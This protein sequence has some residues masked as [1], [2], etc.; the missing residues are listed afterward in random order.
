MTKITACST[1]ASSLSPLEVALEHIA[2][3]GFGRVEISDQ[4]T[5]SKHFSPD[6]MDPVQVR[7]LFDK[8]SLE[9]VAANCTLPPS[10]LISPA[11]G[12]VRQ[13]SRAA[14]VGNTPRLGNGTPNRTDQCSSIAGTGYVVDRRQDYSYSLLNNR[15]GVAETDMGNR[16]YRKG[17]K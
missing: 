2:G 13:T 4:L 10:S 17:F 15:L 5:H 8:Y 16:R 6:T 9:P 3:Y 11:S 7:N 1:L 12:A 14:R